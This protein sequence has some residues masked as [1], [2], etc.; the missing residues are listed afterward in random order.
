MSKKTKA[1]KILILQLE[2]GGEIVS[3]PISIETTEMM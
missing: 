2:F 3:T 1:A